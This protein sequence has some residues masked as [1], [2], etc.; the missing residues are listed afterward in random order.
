[1]YHLRE[2]LDIPMVLAQPAGSDSA[3]TFTKMPHCGEISY[4]YSL[5]ATQLCRLC[6]LYVRYD[7]SYNRGSRISVSTISCYRPVNSIDWIIGAYGKVVVEYYLILGTPEFECS[8]SQINLAA[9]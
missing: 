4:R 2:F 1:M 9:I 8:I 3:T 5:L 6:A 7:L